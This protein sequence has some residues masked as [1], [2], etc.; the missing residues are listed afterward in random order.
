MA[1]GIVSSILSMK[2]ILL[3]QL[4]PNT[5]CWLC[6]KVLT[7]TVREKK[8]R[9]RERERRINGGGEQVRRGE[10]WRG[11]REKAFFVRHIHCN[12]LLVNKSL[13]GSF[14]EK[15]THA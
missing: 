8:W 12:L 7:T 5:V 14:P 4:R 11:G 9:E 10:K 13:L 2:Q 3:K 15:Y 1:S 6:T